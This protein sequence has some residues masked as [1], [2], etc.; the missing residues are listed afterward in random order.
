M[1]GFV[2]SH[3]P[4]S[5]LFVLV[6]SICLVWTGGEILEAQSPDKPGQDVARAEKANGS[7]GV[8]TRLGVGSENREAAVG[9]SRHRPIYEDTRL[10]SFQKRDHHVVVDD[11]FRQVRDKFARQ[12]KSRKKLIGHSEYLPRGTA[13]RPRGIG[14][15]GEGQKPIPIGLVLERL[16]QSAKPQLIGRTTYYVARPLLYLPVRVGNSTKFSVFRF[17]VD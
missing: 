10:G 8:S 13:S 7:L 11:R 1:R 4:L 16:P 3:C 12:V 9:E 15:P 6:F 2:F 14:V 17:P 5:G